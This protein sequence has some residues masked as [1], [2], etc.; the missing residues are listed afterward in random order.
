[1][2]KKILFVC[3]GN[4]CRSPAAE[5]IMNAL[6]EKNHRKGDMVCDSAGVTDWN[7][8]SP[9]DARMTDHARRRG[10]RLAG[11]A[12]QFDPATD[13]HRF[14]YIVTMD[15]KNLADVRAL[16]RNSEERS[17]IHPMTEFCRKFLTEEVPDPYYGGENGFEMVLDILEDACAGLLK[18]PEKTASV[19]DGLPTTA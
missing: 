2:A 11:A 12:R 7:V 5:G 3:L 17:R 16:A 8:G 10:Y 6:I 14:D 18:H 9:P 13:F 15:K 19:H 1:M 4:I